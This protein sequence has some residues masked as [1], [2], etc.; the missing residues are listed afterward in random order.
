MPAFKAAF[1]AVWLLGFPAGHS[2]EMPGE[3]MRGETTIAQGHLPSFLTSG[4]N[5][6]IVVDR[7]GNARGTGYSVQVCLV[8]HS[9][10]GTRKAFDIHRGARPRYAAAA[11]D[12]VCSPLQPTRHDFYFWKQKSGSGLRAVLKQ[13]LDLTGLGG[14]TLVFEWRDD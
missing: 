5:D 14:D 8:N 13:K 7:K 4:D 3:R 6:V 11:G 1:A 12:T 10:S 2:P 9:R